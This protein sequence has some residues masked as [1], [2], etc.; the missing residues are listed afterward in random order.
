MIVDPSCCFLKFS[1]TSTIPNVL[2]WK[3]VTLL[4]EYYASHFSVV[5][6]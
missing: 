2:K 6:T 4:L 5:A 1:A 3:D